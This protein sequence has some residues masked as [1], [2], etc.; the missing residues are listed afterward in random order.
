MGIYRIGDV[1]RSTRE[2]LGITQEELCEGICTVETLSRLE[3]GKRAP[4]RSTFEA[5]ME[6]MGK[7]GEKYCPF[8]RTDELE[9]Q[10]KRRKLEY[11]FATHS[12]AEADKL[13]TK[14]ESDIDLKDRVNEQ[15]IVRSRAIID[16][17]LGKIDNQERIEILESA[18]RLTIPQYGKRSLEYGLY[19]RYEII[20]LCNI[21]IAYAVENNI[22]QTNE[23]LEQLKAYYDNV[24]VNIEEK[25]ISGILV[26]SNLAQCLGVCGEY[27]KSIDVCDEAI[28]L[29]LK[30]QRG[31]SLNNLLYIKALSLEKIDFEKNK[32]TCRNILLQAF[33]ISKQFNNMYMTQHIKKHLTEYYENKFCI[34]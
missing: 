30:V 15:F 29:C 13:L 6:R 19:N 2:S 32:K 5:L 25:A 18:I 27:Q 24:R 34:D 31:I 4:N 17:K 26:M 12:Y 23:I 28:A 33:F 3:N 9:L 22:N 1:I 14:I 16:F 7:S 8:I 21:A 20:I 11:L 10:E